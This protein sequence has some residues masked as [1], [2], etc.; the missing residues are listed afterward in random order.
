MRNR[1]ECLQI[2]NG[3]RNRT[4]KLTTNI[5]LSG[6]RMRDFPLRKGTDKSVHSHNFIQHRTGASSQCSNAGINERYVHWKGENKTLLADSM[7][8]CVQNH[9]NYFFKTTITNIN[10]FSRFAGYKINFKKSIV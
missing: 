1:E 10:K 5:I 3:I 2:V 4:R 7:I 8:P 9:K 6:R